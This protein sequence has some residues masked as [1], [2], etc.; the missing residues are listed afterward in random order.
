MK[1][2]G[3]SKR[4][5]DVFER[6][7]A[8]GERAL[9][10]FIT[11]GDPSVGGTRQILD[12][13][14]RAGADIIELGIPFSDPMADG[15]TIQAS[16]ERALKKHTNINSVLG[17][18]SDLRKKSDIPVILF[19]YYNPVFHYGVDKFARDAARAGADGVL[20]VDLPPEESSELKAACDKRGL[21]L[22]YLLTP[23]SDSSRIKIVT[24]S[25]SGF[26][27][28]VS[29][30]GVTGARKA[31]PKEVESSVRRIK[32]VAKVPVAVGFGV[33][34]TEQTRQIAAY[35]DGVVVGSAI[36]NIISKQKNAKSAALSVGRFVKKLKKGTV[37]VR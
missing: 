24:K 7:E 12:E 5:K 16:S 26:I 36:V 22:I 20:I 31:L 4:L 10:T 6:C 1:N 34:S 2:I 11:A 29:V 28:Y 33:S 23:T 15:P 17:L 13:I 27:Y 3:N 14:D 25:A 30:T 21:D 19:G 9:I 35:A 8:R 18:V 37:G 32:K